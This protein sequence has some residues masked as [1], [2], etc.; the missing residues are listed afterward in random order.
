MSWPLYALIGT[1]SPGAVGGT[2]RITHLVAWRLPDDVTPLLADL[3]IP[4]FRE[5]DLAAVGA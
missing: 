5:D 1:P 2:D 4:Q 3:S